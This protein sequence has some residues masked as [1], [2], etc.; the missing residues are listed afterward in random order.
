MTFSILVLALGGGL[1]TSAN[2]HVEAG[3]RLYGEGK[4]QE[5][6]DEYDRAAR[7][8]SEEPGV[9]FNRGAALFGLGR[10]EEAQKEFLRATEA[11]D[12]QLKEN[13]FYNMGNSFFKQQHY[14]EAFDAYKRALGTDPRDA[15]AKW[16]LE[17]ALRRLRE[18]EQKKQQQDKNKNQDQN[19]D[20]DKDKDK[21]QK[22]DQDQSQQAQQQQKDKQD[23]Q[24]KQQKPDQVPDPKDKKNDEQEREAQ[25]Q[26]ARENKDKPLDKQ[27]AEAVLDALERGEKNLELEQARQRARG[28]RKPVKDW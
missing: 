18:E 12:P 3:N 8:L 22:Q 27:D 15:R 28:R 25:A 19:K 5:A 11:K 24:Q 6:L 21:D 16:N 9:R 13:A 2:G 20:K 17:L 7:K 23:Q 26:K 4:L 10:Y 1:F 14:K